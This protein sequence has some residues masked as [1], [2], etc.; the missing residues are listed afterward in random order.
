VE[1]T[2]TLFLNKLWACI[3]ES[4]SNPGFGV[5]QL[6][7]CMNLSRIQL[8]RKLRY[9]TGYSPAKLILYH[10][11]HTAAN[12]LCESTYTIKEIA[13]QCGFSRHEGFCRCFHQEFKCSPSAYRD[14]F[15]LKRNQ[16][17]LLWEIPFLEENIMLL[18]NLAM[19]EKWLA[20][21]LKIVLKNIS[22]KIFT[23]GQLATAVC[24]SPCS[25]NRRIKGLFRITPQR[26]IRD[27]KL[28]YASELLSSGYGTV[29]EVAY[30]TGFF[31]PAHFSRCFKTAFGCQPN[32]YKGKNRAISMRW[33]EEQLMNQNGK[34]L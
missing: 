24:L 21:L 11:M 10:R 1:G 13:W 33:L 2:E 12:L 27:L 17:E 6:A 34:Q 16:K 7:R 19:Q 25:L 22:N 28:Q 18:L 20:T 23:I 4:G 3:K 29:A 26:L 5:L 9:L 8:N 30:K 15:W 14:N 31:D 32:A